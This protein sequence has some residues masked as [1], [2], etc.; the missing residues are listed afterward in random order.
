[1]REYLRRKRIRF[2]YHPWMWAWAVFEILFVFAASWV[3]PFALICTA[4]LSLTFSPVAS[5]AE[6]MLP[7]TPQ[8]L[9]EERLGRIRCVWLEQTILC[10]LC[11]VIQCGITL[12][13]IEPDGFH[14][15]LY[16][17][18]VANGTLIYNPVLHLLMCILMSIVMYNLFLSADGT[19]SLRKAIRAG[20]FSVDDRK[21][22]GIFWITDAVCRILPI[23]IL[24]P[25]MMGLSSG[26][27]GE[28]PFFEKTVWITAFSVGIVLALIRF[29]R[30]RKS[31]RP[32]T[33]ETMK[34]V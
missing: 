25:G 24:I 2:R 10:L 17:W 9:R 6:G 7:R 31:Y 15:T 33:F 34:C 5:E 16:N 32:E 13:V 27:A 28:T 14:S 23:V 18:F 30:L 21:V 22:R 3:R 8:E 29:V 1:M 20:K 19:E 12:L 26:P 11:Y 4:S